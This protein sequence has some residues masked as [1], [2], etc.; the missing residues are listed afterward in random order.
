MDYVSGV[1]SER[2]GHLTMQE[3]NGTAQVTSS[4]QM[5]GVPLLKSK[6]CSST[7]NRRVSVHWHR[8]RQLVNFT[9]GVYSSSLLTASVFSAISQDSLG[10]KVLK[11][12]RGEEL[13]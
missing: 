12:K 13:G 6:D 1:D 8:D 4:V 2:R 11:V 3:R 5:E 10:E 9:E 7:S